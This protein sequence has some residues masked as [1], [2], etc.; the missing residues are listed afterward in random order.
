MSVGRMSV[1]RLT[2]ARF[3]NPEGLEQLGENLFAETAASGAAKEGQ[4]GQ[5][6]FGSLQ[7]GFLEGSN[8]EAVEEL[9]DM[10]TNQRAFELNAQAFQAAN[11]NLR[12]VTNLNQ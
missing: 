10:I 12:L 6:G 9:V 11:E 1:G 5:D 7:Q 2:A 8:V 3:A 4:F